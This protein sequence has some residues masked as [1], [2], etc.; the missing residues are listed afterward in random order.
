MAGVAILWV[1]ACG[2]AGSEVV[3]PPPVVNRSPAAVGTIPT[4]TVSVGEM[5]AVDVSS[6]FSDPDGDALSYT[7]VSSNAGVAGIAVT[8]SSV[9]VTALAKGGAT[10]TVEARDP[11]GLIAQQRFVVTVPNRAPEAV[12]AIPAQTVTAGETAA[13]DVS[14]HFGDPDGDSLTYAA[15]SSDT[16]VA[17]VS[18]S[19]DSVAVTALAKGLTTITVTARDGEGLTA[20]QRFGVVVDTAK[21]TTLEVSPESAQLNTDDTVRL[22]ATVFDQIGREMEDVDVSWTSGDPGVAT[23]SSSGL[24]TAPG[25]GS[26]TV[27]AAAGDARGTAAVT[28]REP[29]DRVNV[30]PVSAAI[31]STGELLLRARALD[32]DSN[33]LD[34][35]FQWK[36]SDPSV[37]SLDQSGVVSGESTGSATITVSAGGKEATSEITVVSANSQRDA[38]T[39][40]YGATDGAT[41][42]ENENWVT[43]APLRDW[44]GVTASRSDTVTLL[45][46]LQNELNGPLPT[47]LGNLTKLTQLIITAAKGVTGPIPTSLARLSELDEL[48]LSGLGLTG[49]IPP[50]LAQLD[51]LTGLFLSDLQL[52][53]SIPSEFG[54]F[55]ALGELEISGSGITGSIPS[56]LG[57]IDSLYTL[58]IIETSVSGEIP[59]EIGDLSTLEYLDLSQNALTGAIPPELGQL[60]SLWYLDLQKNDLTG[61]FPAELGQLGNLTDLDLSENSGLTGPL[62][63]A[64]SALTLEWLDLRGTDLCVPTEMEDWLNGID[65]AHAE[66]CDDGQ[67][68]VD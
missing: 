1:A 66:L 68:D 52:S 31:S 25:G 21:P 9:A 59:P 57:Q 8:G 36:S 56:E 15:A 29:V 6:Y 65:T 41:W 63:T 46:L 58:T 43:T 2:D 38:L 64:L 55:A 42:K 48:N 47:E 35:S 53:G 28:V 50:E 14:S 23:V 54:D 16:E 11:Q 61:A 26:T 12:G 45:W 3:S 32:E 34:V 49:T 33:E 40:L 5:A 18:V 10:V 51:K 4:Q 39:S 30:R 24:V 13:V 37:A 20:D 17:T 60:D 27:T 67:D 44:H 19:G 62:P 7:A 22:T